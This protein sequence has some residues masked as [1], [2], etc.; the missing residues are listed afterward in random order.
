[1]G[2]ALISCFVT[3]L[4]T[5]PTKAEIV[6]KKGRSYF[7]ARGDV[8]WEVPTE[9]RVIALTFDDGPNPEYTPQVL[10]LLK[11]YH[12]KATFF[13]IGSRV[14]KYPELVRREAV[15]GHEV[16]NHTF[17]HPNLRR[18]TVEKLQ[19]ELAKAQ[20][21]IWAVS[22]HTPHLFRPPGGYY[23]ETIV[24]TAKQAGYTV[25]M[26]SWHLDTRDWSCPGVGKIVNRVLSNARN[27]DIVLFHDHGGNRRQTIEALQQILP[28]LQQRGYQ[29]ITISQLLE[30]KSKS[31]T[32]NEIPF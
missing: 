1:V 24:N 26:W 10:D 2:F 7:E 22:E 23:D 5:V 17:S 21:V 4:A 3:L 29:F 18:F 15:E 12:A 20:D 13:V 19:E 14:E 31:N 28:E 16:A 25:V 32:K 27:G 30:I 8:V 11:Q 6:E 9:Q